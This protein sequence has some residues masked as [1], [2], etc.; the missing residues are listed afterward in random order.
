MERA[1][2]PSTP[3]E[4]KQESVGTPPALPAP[5]LRLPPCY[6]FYEE[7]FLGL[8]EARSCWRGMLFRSTKVVGPTVICPIFYDAGRIPPGD[9]LIWLNKWV[10]EAR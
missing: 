1:S 6:L 5:A 9:S 8:D 10:L 4:Q 7:D 2:T 3:H